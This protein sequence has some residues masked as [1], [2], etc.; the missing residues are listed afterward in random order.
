MLLDSKKIITLLLVFIL[1]LA[2]VSCS[3][4]AINSSDKE[5]DFINIADI[6]IPINII[7]LDLNS[8]NITDIEP[9]YK[10]TSLEKL[11]LRNNPI[12]LEDIIEFKSKIPDC[13][14]SWSINLNYTF[15]DNDTTII[16]FTS[17]EEL[18]INQL[19]NNLAYFDSLSEVRLSN[20]GVSAE[21]YK[22]LKDLYPDIDF[23]MN[24]LIGGLWFNTDERAIDLTECVSID[25]NK[26]TKLLK[27]FNALDMVKVADELGQNL[28]GR[29]ISAYSGDGI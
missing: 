2:L 6:E 12:A 18:D 1:F 27:Y 29:L 24:I 23:D 11:D 7:E 19:I 17:S 20:Q 4:K 21:Q 26:L 5:S 15:F 16:D 8:K 13:Q 25:Q 28:D 9:L 3:N 22:K 10:L 14:V